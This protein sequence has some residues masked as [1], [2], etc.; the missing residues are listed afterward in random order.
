MKKL[1]LASLL[2]SFL[3]AQSY[4]L[5]SYFNS[6]VGT[7]NIDTVKNSENLDIRLE[8]PLLP[9]SIL[10]ASF[11]NVGFLIEREFNFQKINDSTYIEKLSD[12]E[13]TYSLSTNGW[14]LKSYLG[15]RTE[16]K[17][18]VGNNY[19]GTT[20]VDIVRDELQG[21][22]KRNFEIFV[23][24][25]RYFIELPEFIY[26]SDFK[27]LN[28][29]IRSFHR[30]ENDSWKSYEKDKDVP[31]GNISV[32]FKEHEAVKATGE[33]KILFFPIDFYI[34]KQK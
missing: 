15:N 9:D 5:Y 8:I 6:H 28:F 22:Y 26:D 23:G 17:N 1:I 34:E 7:I 20:L 19:E 13:F 33:V 21:N 29:D 31:F 12:E 3:N 4:N 2:S 30:W 14:Q 32:F 16:K 11:F 10:N 18:L 27:R 25:L 24:G